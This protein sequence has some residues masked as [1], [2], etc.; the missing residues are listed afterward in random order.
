MELRERVFRTGD[1]VMQVRNNYDIPYAGADGKEDGAGAF[2][3]DMGIVERVNP[4][5]GTICVRSE[6]RY[7]IYPREHLQMCIRDRDDT[8][9]EDEAGRLEDDTSEETEPGAE[10]ST[11]EEPGEDMRQDESRIS[12]LRERIR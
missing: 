5:D 1:K 12:A 9:E 4:R 6:D 7:F 10:D 3:G 2:N 8:A 11:E